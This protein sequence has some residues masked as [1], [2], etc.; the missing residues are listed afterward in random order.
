MIG[1]VLFAF[2]ASAQNGLILEGRFKVDGGS[3]NGAKIVVEKNG[4]RLQTKEGTSR[5]E[6]ELDFQAVYLVSFEKDGFVSKKLRFDTHV[7]TDRI[8]YGFEIFEF[9]V[10]IFEQ[11]DDVNMVIFNQPVGKI[12]FSDLIDEFDYDTDYT[13]SIQAQ[14]DDTMD[15]IEDKKEEIAD[16]VAAEEKAQADVAKQT[17]NLTTAAQK[18]EDQGKLEEAIQKLKEANGIKE[19]PQTEKKIQELEKKQ[20]QQAKQQEKQDEF[21]KVLADAEAAMAQG[22]LEGAKKLFEQANGVIGGD[23]KVQAGLA[24][25]EKGI[26]QAAK[27]KEAAAAAAA[28]AEEA[29][30][31]AAAKTETEE[32]VIPE[33]G[34]VI[35][36]DVRVG[37]EASL[38]A[39]LSEDEKFDGMM[40]RAEIQQ[41]EFYEEEEQKQLR[42]DYPRRKTVETEEAG[43][44]VI[45]W[46][47]INYGEFVKTYKR[48]KHN[49][50]GEYFFIDG[51][52]TNRRYWEHETQ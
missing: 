8:E 52:A 19:N 6:I 32:A 29:A 20:E 31:N 45:T 35:L 40:R 22:D 26:A 25:I 3:N 49:W 48:V 13:K 21:N 43:N 46:V 15:E 50:G 27:E 28:A 18:L 14:I 16:Q 42:D 51:Q 23:S 5:F 24:K 38:T 36:G 2:A 34:T 33:T 41:E 12:S 39:R 4:Q 47:Y 7:P 11:Y 9:K 30:A 10:E 1:L 17:Q 37:E 44:S